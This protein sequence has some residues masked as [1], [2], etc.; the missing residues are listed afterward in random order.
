MSS[1]SRGNRRW[2]GHPIPDAQSW[3]GRGRCAGVVSEPEP[4]RVF[5]ESYPEDGSATTFTVEPIGEVECRVTIT[6]EMKSRSGPLGILE[7]WL[8]TRFLRGVY[9]RELRL[10]E[11]VA[12]RK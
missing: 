3:A 11:E 4:G 12:R 9:K 2:D 6:T 1:W 5:V 10:L 7:R 8:A